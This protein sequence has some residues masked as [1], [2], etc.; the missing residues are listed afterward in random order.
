MNS[1]AW[2]PV[3][4]ILCQSVVYTPNAHNFLEKSN[5]GSKHENRLTARPLGG[6]PAPASGPSFWLDKGD[7]PRPFYD[8]PPPSWG[9]IP[10]TN[11]PRDKGHIA[12][13]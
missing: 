2:F 6:P 5:W 7:T 12:L 11:S 3:G 9:H 13:I 8:P 10:H 1:G 4:Q